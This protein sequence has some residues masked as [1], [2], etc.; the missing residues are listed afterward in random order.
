[1]PKV[2]TLKH[3]QQRFSERPRILNVLHAIGL[4]E[5]CTQTYPQE[6][7]LL[8]KYAASCKIAVEIGSFQGVSGAL[9]AAAMPRDGV[10]YCIDPWTETGGKKDP[11]FAIF[12]RQMKRKGVAGKVRVLRGTSQ[13][14]AGQLPAQVDF[15]FIDGDHS[16]S[17]ITFDWALAK[18]IVK[19]GG[20]VCLHDALVPASEPWRHFGS[21]DY[22]ADVIR[23]D[24]G[25]ELIDHEHSMAVLRRL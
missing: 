8:S 5:G 13:D 11:S 14:M 22:F 17:A 3:L 16:R 18:R 4:V 6:L 23:R 15:M 24:P 2:E 19:S 1:M 10:L 7:A 9:I 25:F 12:C 20:Y 21:S